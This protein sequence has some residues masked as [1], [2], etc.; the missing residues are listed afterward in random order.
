MLL[1]LA[2]ALG[3]A[4]RFEEVTPGFSLGLSSNA[5]WLALAFFGT[6]RCSS[7]LRAARFGALLETGANAGY[8]AHVLLLE[9]GTPLASVA[10][11]PAR[12]LLLG[13]AAGAFFGAAGRLGVE[14]GPT[15]SGASRAGRAQD[16]R[17]VSAAL[18]LSGAVL[19]EAADGLR[20]TDA[21][22]VAFALGLPLAA[23]GRL[24][25]AGGAA[26]VVIGAV[27]MTGVLA[28]LSP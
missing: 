18:C 24:R 27:A 28:P 15:P 12:W 23:G 26:A 10:G 2:L 17:T 1:V 3:A 8:Y 7:L 9:P 20:W 22:A 21:P 11:S 13:L 14:G 19:V 6:R 25:V 4:S 5:A 16:V